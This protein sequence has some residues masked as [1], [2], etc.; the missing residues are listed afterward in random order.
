MSASPSVSQTD[1][2]AIRYHG[3][4]ALRAWAMSMGLVLHAAWIMSPGE[5]GA[6]MTD[7][8]A[9]SIMSYIGDGIH[10]FRMQLFFVLAGFFACLLIRKRGA[11]RFTW[12]RILRIAVPLV[13]FW[14]ILWP[15]MITQFF[16]AQI[17]S[18][19]LLTDSTAWQLTKDYFF[20]MTVKTTM[21]MH[22]WFIYYLLWI[23]AMVLVVRSVLLWLDPQSKL[24]DWISA[25]FDSVLT[26]PWSVGVL[27]MISAPLLYPMDGFFGVQMDAMSLYPVWSGLFSYLVYF[28]IGWLIFRNVGSLEKMTRHWRPFL[29]AGVAFT[30]GY[31][32]FS[33]ATLK[34][35]YVT[36]AYPNLAV[37]DV[38][39][40]HEQQQRDF[41][42]LKSQLLDSE[43]T[44]IAGQV[45]A[46]LPAKHQAMVRQH[47][48][49]SENQLT[50]LM[51]AISASTLDRAAFAGEVEFD[52]SS[53]TERARKILAMPADAREPEQT[54]WLNR[55]IVQA[56]FP[57]IIL[58]QDAQQPYYLAIRVAYCYCYS[59]TSWLMILG[60][61]GFS[62]HYF[63][64]HSGFWRYFSDSS[65]WIYLM[66]LVVQFQILLWWGETPWHWSI[67]FLVY[68]VG[69]ALVLVPTYHLL[70]RP[71]WLGWLLNGKMEPLR[72]RR[73]TVVREPELTVSSPETT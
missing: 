10:M 28:V 54:Q 5:N 43:S 35:G 32:F 53:L 60:C 24:R 25:R 69:T 3:L 46:N 71:T 41:P 13:L 26:T 62:L 11:W 40:D 51:K 67:K 33:D 39:Y 22:M 30:I 17:K 52:E 44:S 48:Q 56:G 47:D 37:A 16:A 49:V 63:R 12:N 29:A 19:A 73:R 59:L 6:P 45:W 2:A 61:F 64:S 27:A 36:P 21:T 50:G 72:I 14:F 42:K 8:S 58:A 65:Y 15:S 9:S 31:Y 38:I 23:Y 66:H 20:N 7:A 68:V 57:G 4:D 34:G 1:P 18:G 55:E 70:V